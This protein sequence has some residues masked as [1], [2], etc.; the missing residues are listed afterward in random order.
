MRSLVALI[1]LAAQIG[2]DAYVRQLARI[3]DPCAFRHGTW[4]DLIAIHHAALAAA[5]RAGDKAAEAQAQVSP[6]YLHAAS[7]PA[8]GPAISLFVQAF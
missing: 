8:A 6:V 7:V 2:F 3:R 1:N 4:G 5:R